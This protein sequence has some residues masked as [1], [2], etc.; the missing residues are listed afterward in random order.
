MCNSIGL[1]YFAKAITIKPDESEHYVER[2]KILRRLGR[3][4]D[5][6]RDEAEAERLQ[7]AGVIYPPPDF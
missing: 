5:A 6:A 1:E 7:M 2:A 3:N 4:E